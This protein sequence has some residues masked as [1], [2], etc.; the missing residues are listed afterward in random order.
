[1]RVSLHTRLLLLVA[2]TVAGLSVVSLLVV[3]AL[4]RREVTESV[5]RDV[6]TTG[7]VLGQLVRERGGAL[8]SRCE[9]LA[10]QPALKQYIFGQQGHAAREDWPTVSGYATECREQMHA[11]SVL[12]TDRDGRPIGESDSTSPDRA[13]R[14]GE[15]GV[16][17]ALRNAPWFGIVPRSNRASLA[18][19]VPIIDP[20]NRSVQG[21]ITAYIDI[22]S[23]IAAEMKQA[24]GSDVA[25]VRGGHVLGSTLRALSHINARS[26][27]PGVVS[28]G[29]QFLALYAPL[30]KSNPG[31]KLG[32]ITL[33]PY[34]EAMATA[35][36]IGT[37]MGIVSIATLL[38][39]LFAGTLVARGI[40]QP[41]AGV[42][43]AAKALQQ[44]EW[45]ERLDTAR[46]DELGLLQTVFN[47]MTRA[48]RTS[49]EKLLALIDKDPLTELD[50]H[51]RFQERLSQEMVRS[52]STGQPLSLLLLDIDHFQQ[53]N[54][55]FGHSAGDDALT[56]IA[57]VIRR[58]TPETATLAR[59]GGEEFAILAPG[60]S[61][62][63]AEEIAEVFRRALSDS[64]ENGETL[65]VSIGIAEASSSIGESDGLA[66][67]AELAVSRAKQLGRNRVCRFESS[68]E[69]DDQDPQ[70]L[71]RFL[72]DGSL[73][74]IQALAAAVDA[75]DAYTRGHSQRVAEYSRDLAR[76][77]GLSEAEIELVFITGTLHD[78]GKIGVPD[79]ILKKPGRLDDEER[80]IMETHPALGEVI[81]R[82]APQLAATLP[83]VRHHHERWDG[84]GYPD[85]LAG[86]AIP[87]IA[88]LLALADTFDAMT[89]DRPYRRGM[90][91]E[92]A[93][94]E[95]ERGRGTQFDPGLAPAF[96]EM[97]SERFQALAA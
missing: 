70:Q 61:V 25:F 96:V 41:L 45:P 13:S 60:A 84:R 6:R 89:S 16:A 68:L 72:K 22:D 79:A 11:G 19:A 27:S 91:I 59:Y 32:F 23:T 8:Q 93:L 42:I 28:A 77:I 20:V 66:L 52:R 76:R 21:T 74:T 82:K 78:V 48:V 87:H 62:E 1:M 85:G 97:M 57:E 92:V 40:T 26:D 43:G 71:H 7:T 30:P 36:R 44:G 75:K 49:Q 17:S 18:A 9:I 35:S 2:G 55:R 53:F 5:R 64:P 47:D 95:I 46:T 81:V 63:A 54:H 39:A 14:A 86:E 15:A 94:S 58:C 56:Q 10:N 33:V 37:L 4:V 65:T 90:A 38:A 31:D 29:G 50:N 83:G 88:R 67:A 69:S 80:A 34:A 73:A 12:I 3:G 24:V 51:R